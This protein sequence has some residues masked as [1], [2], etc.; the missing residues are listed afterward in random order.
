[1]SRLQ[2]LFCEKNNNN[3]DDMV[4]ILIPVR[5]EANNIRE[6]L[7]SIISQDYEAFE[8][9]ILDDRSTDKTAKIVETFQGTTDCLKL[10]NGKELPDGWVGK[11]WACHQLSEHAK[12]QLILFMD[13]DT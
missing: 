8:V 1:M 4:S 10:I 9:I 13:A 3:L 2:K 6:C 5:N 7:E 12:G 11:N